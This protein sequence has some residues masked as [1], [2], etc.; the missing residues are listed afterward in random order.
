[1]E[2]CS[3]T[4]LG[5]RTK[6]LSS[7]ESQ[8]EAGAASSSNPEGELDL[9][10]QSNHQHSPTPRMLSVRCCLL[11]AGC[12][13]I[14]NPISKFGKAITVSE[15]EV[16]A[17]VIFRIDKESLNVRLCFCSLF[18]VHWFCFENPFPL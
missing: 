12:S 5:C 16:G 9:P 6:S 2:V 11:V 15:F 4:T 14:A 1:M 13:L 3:S 8:S 17:A 10:L 7:I 18:C